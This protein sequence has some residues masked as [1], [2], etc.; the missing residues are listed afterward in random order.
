MLQR[1]LSRPASTCSCAAPG[2]RAP[3]SPARLA[4]LRSPTP[5]APPALRQSSRRS[6]TPPA[7]LRSPRARARSRV[8]PPA[9]CALSWPPAC[10][11]CPAPGPASRDAH[12]RAART[13]PSRTRPRSGR[14]P[15]LPAF[16]RPASLRA[17]GRQHTPTLARARRLG[18]APRALP[19]A[20]S[21]SCAPRLGPAQ[22]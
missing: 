6:R 3:R 17:P 21:R 20:L 12:A 16:L 15:A 22:P 4:C 7:R 10:R 5:H 19:P 13:W 8:P 18:A 11:R 2:L 14:P 1:R 9:A